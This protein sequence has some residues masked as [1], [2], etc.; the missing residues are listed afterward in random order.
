VC[1]LGKRVCLRDQGD[2]RCILRL[3]RVE[4]LW[5]RSERF[6]HTCMVRGS[7]MI[8][9][10]SLEHEDEGRKAQKRR[11]SWRQALCFAAFNAVRRSTAGQQETSARA[12][13]NTRCA[14]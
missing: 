10:L 6:G 11:H 5:E 1:L 12:A 8:D 3:H 7:R 13:R 2:I 14:T 9:K 4:Y